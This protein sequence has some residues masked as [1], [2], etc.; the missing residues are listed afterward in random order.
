MRCVLDAS[1]VLAMLND[2]P[3]G[4]RAAVAIDSS[5][6]SAVNLAEVAAALVRRG[7]SASQARAILEALALTVVPVD[8]AMAI[9]AGLMRQITDRAGLS[10]A[11]RFCL[12]LSRRL[13]SPALTTDRDWA[14]VASDVGVVVEVIR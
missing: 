9:E 4:E 11:D 14:S 5:V 1:A 13:S 3:G 6:I 7:N 10:L 12:V 8:E 2:E